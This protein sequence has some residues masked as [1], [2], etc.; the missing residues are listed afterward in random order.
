MNRSVFVILIPAMITFT[1]AAASF[2]CHKATR[3]DELAVCT[4]QKLSD[5]DVEM[6]VKYNFLRGLLAMGAAGNMVDEQKA[7]LKQRHQCNSDKACLKSVYLNR[8]MVL[9]AQYDKIDKPF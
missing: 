4:S 9:D 3:A 8:I 2:D 6:S 5:L 7:W 1:T